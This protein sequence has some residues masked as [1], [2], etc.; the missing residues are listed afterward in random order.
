MNTFCSYFN[1]GVCRSCSQLPVAYPEQL[2]NKETRLKDRL[3]NWTEIDYRPTIG[4]REQFFRNKAKMVITGTLLEPIIGLAGEEK[5]DAGKDIR[6]CT[7]HSPPITHLLNAL[8]EFIQ[9]AKL[10]PYG[11]ELKTGEL[12]GLIIYYSNDTSAMYL[13]FVLRSKESLDR[14]KKNLGSLTSKFPELECVSANIQP[15]PH[16]ILEGP[17]EIFFTEKNYIHHQLSQI[18]MK[19]QPQGFV[20]TNQEV[21]TKLYATAA[22]W[23][24]E[25]KIHRF[26]ELFCGQ[27][28]FSFFASAHVK[29]ALG[30]EINP[31]AVARANDTAQEAALNHLKFVASDASLVKEEVTR[32]APDLVLANPPRRGLGQALELFKKGEFRYFIYSSCNAETMAHDLEELKSVYRPVKAQLFDMFPHTEHF[33]TLVLLKAIDADKRA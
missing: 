25:L 15:I 32:F 14:I 19:L 9:L 22:E 29:E 7:L 8:P 11:I 27:G 31:D 10:V 12:K 28:A 20:Q 26:T 17:E 23:M 24:K 2:R 33:E 16:A 3:K 13:R 18:H 21:A 6:N 4:S 5:L 30:I 1:Q